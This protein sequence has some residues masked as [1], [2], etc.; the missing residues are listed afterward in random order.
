MET[1]T[2]SWLM[3]DL[4]REKVTTLLKLHRSYLL[5]DD[6]IAV[7]SCVGEENWK[8]EGRYIWWKQRPEWCIAGRGPLVRERRWPLKA[9]EKARK[10]LLP[11]RASG[12][13]ASC[14]RFYFILGRFRFE[15]KA[16]RITS[17]YIPIVLSC[18]DV[19]NLLQQ[20][21]SNPGGFVEENLILLA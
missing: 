12:R 1:S 8:S 14:L 6:S 9:G 11:Q 15:P 19:G 18:H 16:P 13:N 7:S 17:R 2:V 21:E 3:S 5:E 10:W 4:A 20:Q